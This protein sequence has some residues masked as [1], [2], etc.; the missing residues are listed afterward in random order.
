[1][2][3]IEADHLNNSIQSIKAKHSGHHLGF[4][5]QAIETSAFKK[6]SLLTEV[7]E[8]INSLFPRRPGPRTA[9]VI[10]KVGVSRW[11]SLEC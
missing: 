1:M 10:S 5:L 9:P 6:R 3:E 4:Q 7:K 8:D 2:P 11:S